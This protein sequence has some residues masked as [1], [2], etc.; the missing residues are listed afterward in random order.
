MK[1][2]SDQ[3]ARWG[4]RLLTASVI[5]T[6]LSF[7]QV[8]VNG[9]AWSPKPTQALIES[10]GYIG[11]DLSSGCLSTRNPILETTCLSDLPGGY[12]YHF[13]CGMIDPLGVIILLP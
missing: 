6:I 7:A 3:S 2:P 4:K 9:V 8:A 13:A 12:C 5:L 10:M 1:A 11:P